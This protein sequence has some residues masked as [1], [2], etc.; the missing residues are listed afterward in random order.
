LET[1]LKIMPDT[2]IFS[3]LNHQRT[4]LLCQSWAKMKSFGRACGETP[5]SLPLELHYEMAVRGSIGK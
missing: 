2:L 5:K 1:P 4:L 3:Q